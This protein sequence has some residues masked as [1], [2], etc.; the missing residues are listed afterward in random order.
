MRSS[1]SS[2]KCTPLRL[3]LGWLLT[4]AV[5][6]GTCA[7]LLPPC[8]HQTYPAAIQD[9]LARLRTAEGQRLIVIGGSGVPFALDCGLIENQFPQYTVVDFG[10]YAEMGVVPMLDWVG[11]ELRAG[12]LVVLMPEQNPLS[13]SDHADGELLLQAC[14]GNPSLLL[15]L[16]PRRWGRVITQIP[17]YA[18][19]KLRYAC[20]GAPRPEGV[21]TRA[22]LNEYGDMASPLRDHNILPSGVQSDVPIRFDPIS[23]DFLQETD[24]FCRIAKKQG[25]EVVWHFSPMNAAAVEASAEEIDGYYDRLAERIGVPILGDPHQCILPS[26]WFYDSNFHLN[27]S[28]SIVF[29]KL[30]VDDLSVYL[31]QTAPIDI[32]LPPMPT[33]AQNDVDGDDS[34]ADCFTY[35]PLG[36]GW[37][38]T[39]LT[40]RGRSAQT[41]TLPTH[42][43]GLP[44]TAYAPDLFHDDTGL[45][46]VTIQPNLRLLHDGSFSG[47]TTLRRLI[48]TGEDPDRTAVG[49][50]LMEGASFQIFVPADALEGYRRSYGWQQYEPWL[51]GNFL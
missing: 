5:V 29:T 44:V 33:M 48:L 42:Y 11:G 47:C 18:A 38:I 3:L 24:I 41:L 34:D 25:A 27:T 37:Q 26:G 16:S 9:K 50:G 39:G 23:D 10:L 20:T 15:S 32:P 40:E 7:F 49:E 14:D 17:I 13:L 6:L 31:G 36:N 43:D 45:Q 21:Y 1:I 19:K 28:G 35:A 4:A 12:D 46:E 30:L 51:F 2:F 8:F 22:A